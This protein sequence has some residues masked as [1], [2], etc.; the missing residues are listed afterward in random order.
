MVI[1]AITLLVIRI[2]SPDDYGL[3]AISQVFMNIMGGF[4]N[5]GL[6]DALV[7]QENTPKPV[8][9]SVFGLLLLVSVLLT[10]ALSLAAYPISIW[11]HDPR[12]VLLLQ[13]SSLGFLL[14]GMT[15]IPRVYL[16]K[17][18]RIRPV[19]VMEMS[20]SLVGALV[21]V[22]FAYA[23]Q[24]VWAL[25]GGW[26]LSNIV[27]A[28]G[29]AVL[30][31]EYWVWPRFDLRLAKPLYSYGAYR[32]L[33]Y[34]AW[35]ALTSSDVLI[36]GWWL[37]ATDLGLY[38]VALNFA[39]MP[40]SK[41]APVINSVAFPA[42]SIV[43]GRPAEARFYALKAMRLMALVLV[44]VFFGISAVAPEI[45]GLVFGAKWAAAEPILAI[46]SLAISFRAILL[47]IPNYLQGIGDARA[48][49]W[50][51]A[52]G[53][54]IFPPAFIVGAHWGILGVCYAWVIGYP[55][56]FICNSF[57]A[58]RYGRLEFKTLLA[59]PLRPM[60]A[61]VVMIIVIATLRPRLPPDLIEAGRLAVLVAA[62][63]ATYI[64]VMLL[65]FRQLAFEIVSVV[66]SQWSSAA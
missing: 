6:G 54:A 37:G 40:L 18:F 63:A 46:L 56:L 30:G 19:F 11:Y 66:R 57:I 7:Q 34:L 1:W 32:T 65:A 17:S 49:F 25:M 21:V 39:G 26:L 2:L 44:P 14:N 61:G 36:L 16:T 8:I 20:S 15:T 35:V 31:A 41:I 60:V 45:V 4:A 43:Q 42:F 50:C 28:I 47:V 48:A 29:L 58:A 52:T 13:V 27:R 38:S 33:E 23:G 59:I 55:L 62:G 10:A 53:A 3:M 24:G 12:L 5:L 51:T 9:A 22:L 64:G